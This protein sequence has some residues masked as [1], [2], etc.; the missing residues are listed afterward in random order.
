MV[1]TNGIRLNVMVYGNGPDVVLLHGFPDSAYLW[2]KQIP[3]LVEA[4]YRVIAPDLRGS[5]DSDA[6]EGKINYTLDKLIKDVAGLVDHLGVK[7]ARVV[8]HDW[9]AILGWFFAIEHPEHVDRYVALSVGHPTAYQKAGIAQKLRSWYAVAYQPPA[10]PEIL[11][12]S[13]NWRFTRVLT[14]NHPEMDRWIEDKSRPG[15]LTAA[16]NWYRA[17]LSS[18]LFGS[19]PHAK[20]PVFGI[21][22]SGDIYLTERQMTTSSNY[23]D[24]PWRYERIENSSHWIPLD[25]PDRLNALLLEYFGE[26][27]G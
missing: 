25:A 23:V 26:S 11:S 20:V 5:G 19:T 10:I 13:L 4:G 17:N 3:A 27:L 7:R 24:A 9:G 16:I 8:G 6:P 12:K 18:I 14:G 2:R 15:R 22:S 1:E 21:W